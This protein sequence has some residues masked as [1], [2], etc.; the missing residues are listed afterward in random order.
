MEGRSK[1][2]KTIKVRFELCKDTLIGEKLVAGI[3][4]RSVMLNGR[5]ADPSRATKS[6]SANEL[7]GEGTA[8]VL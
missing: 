8:Q 2:I 6:Y 1:E 3:D 4:L 7:D 5:M